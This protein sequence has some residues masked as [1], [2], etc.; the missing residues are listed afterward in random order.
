MDEVVRV[1]SDLSFFE[2]FSD[3]GVRNYRIRLTSMYYLEAFPSYNEIIFILKKRQRKQSKKNLL[4][5]GKILCKQPDVLR[6]WVAHEDLR[7]ALRTTATILPIYIQKYVSAAE[8]NKV[9]TIKH[10]GKYLQ[11]QNPSL[12]KQLN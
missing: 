12:L 9:S 4:E 10:F 5:A 6:V 8:K 3:K 2:T 7:F 1:F 11:L